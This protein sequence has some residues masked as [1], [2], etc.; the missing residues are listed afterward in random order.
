VPTILSKLC[1]AMKK[2]KEEKGGQA[3]QA[4]FTPNPLGEGEK[5]KEK[6]KVG[7]VRCNK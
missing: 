2:D 6:K 7:N 5:G 3:S 1:L 4:P